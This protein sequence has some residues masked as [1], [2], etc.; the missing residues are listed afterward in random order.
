MAGWH[1]DA[2]GSRQQGEG[3]THRQLYLMHCA[4]STAAGAPAARSC[5]SAAVASCSCCHEA[6]HPSRLAPPTAAAAAAG[7]R[8]PSTY[9]REGRCFAPSPCCRWSRCWLG[10]WTAMRSCCCCAHGRRRRPESCS[11]APPVLACVVRA[12]HAPPCLLLLLVVLLPA[13]RSRPQRRGEWRV[14]ASPM[15]G[16]GCWSAAASRH[17][18]ST[19]GGVMTTAPAC[20]S[21]LA[22]ACATLGADCCGITRYAPSA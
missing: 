4:C 14:P 20:L 19:A 10:A 6:P 17:Q 5:R 3:E 12:S 7:T 2:T 22:A 8:C 1:G 16:A 15:V 21:R 13:A 18:L 9:S 11:S